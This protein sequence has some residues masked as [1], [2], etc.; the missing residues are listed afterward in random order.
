MAIKLRV[1]YM[2]Q[3]VELWC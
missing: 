3:A 2:L 1:L